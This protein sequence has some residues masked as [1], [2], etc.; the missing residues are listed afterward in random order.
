MRIVLLCEIA[1]LFV[2]PFLIAF[3]RRR[4]AIAAKQ[5]AFALATLLGLLA[6]TYSLYLRNPQTLS[7]LTIH[8]WSLASAFALLG[9]IVVYP[10]SIWLQRE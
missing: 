3:L 1:F 10:L 4:R 6:G 8:D 5:V 9:W 7:S 2:A